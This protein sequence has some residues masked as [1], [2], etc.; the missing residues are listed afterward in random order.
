MGVNLRLSGTLAATAG[1][2]S[3]TGVTIELRWFRSQKVNIRLAIFTSVFL[4]GTRQFIGHCE[5][6]ERDNY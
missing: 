4:V 6:W 3:S 5:Q 1:A 2:S